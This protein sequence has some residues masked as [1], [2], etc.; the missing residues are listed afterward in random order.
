[1]ESPKEEKEFNWEQ[2]NLRDTSVAAVDFT[3]QI[4]WFLQ[5]PF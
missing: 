3:Q 2:W 4:F 1:M 5:V